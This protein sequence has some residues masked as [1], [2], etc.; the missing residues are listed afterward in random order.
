MQVKIEPEQQ[1]R[2][3]VHLEGRLDLVSAAEVDEDVV[4]RLLDLAVDLGAALR[5]R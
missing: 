4:T 5:A 1:G 2:A 3:V